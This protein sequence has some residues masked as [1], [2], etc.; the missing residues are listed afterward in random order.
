MNDEIVRLSRL[1]IELDSVWN[2]TERQ[3]K[4]DDKKDRLFASAGGPFFCLRPVGNPS[5][6]T[7]RAQVTVHADKL[8][9]SLRADLLG[10]DRRGSSSRT[11]LASRALNAGHEEGVR[12]R[13]DLHRL[14]YRGLPSYAKA[15]SGWRIA[16]ALVTTQSSRPP[17]A[18]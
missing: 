1:A 5:E 16:L 11:S 9:R 13:V 6:N 17:L 18:M 14:L 12:I 7:V 15:G 10:Y 3:Q 4:N 8:V 2:D